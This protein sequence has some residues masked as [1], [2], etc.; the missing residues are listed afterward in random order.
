MA[1]LVLST[2]GNAL[3]G[4]IGGAIGALVG[5]SIDQQLLGP[6]RR[7]P[8]LGDLTVQTS[9]YGTQ[10]P[11]IYGAMRVAGTVIW[12]TDLVES[13]QTTGAKGQPDATYS[14]S[15]SIA[16]ALSSRPVASI[17]RIWADGKLLRGENGDFKVSTTFRFYNGSEDQQIDPLIGSIEEIAN[18]PAYRG[19]AV[20]VFENL[21]LADYGN[22]IPFLTFEIAADDETPSIGAILK[23]ASNGLV[24]SDAGQDILGYAAYGQSIRSAIEPLIDNYAIELFDDG[25]QLRTPSRSAQSVSEDDWGNSA[26]NNQ[27]ARIQREQIPARTLPGSLRLSFYDPARDYQTG[28]ARASA[29]EQQASEVKR[30]LPAATSASDAKSLVQRMLAIEWARRDRLTLRLPPR[31]LS[32]EPGDLLELQLNPGRWS[33]EKCTIDGFVVVTELLPAWSPSPVVLADAG[34]IITNQDVE[35]SPLSLALLDVGS[36]LPQ[37][38]TQPTLLLAASTA[39]ADWKRRSVQV[40]IPGLAFVTQTAGR[41]SVLGRALTILSLGEPYLID[42]I[43]S[44]DVELTDA[45]QWLTSCDDDALSAGTNL[46]AVG[47]ELIQ[48][49]EATPLA[50]GQFR[51]SRLLRGRGGTEWASSSHVVDD[52]FCVVELGTVQPLP[53]PSWSIGALVTAS[54]QD[55]P[56]AAAIV[57]ADPLRPPNPVNLTAAIQPTGDLVVNWTRRSRAGWAWFD[58]VDT[59]LA[60]RLEQYRITVTGQVGTME[61]WADQPS[62]SIPAGNLASLGPGVATLEVR[63]VGDFAASRP[64]Q[65]SITFP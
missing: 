58:E 59:P 19:S 37:T 2:V 51:L 49:G 11:R 23:D 6:A 64:A 30:E 48:F 35:A 41:K 21:E 56:D 33:V 32:L 40:T 42:T 14:Y 54:A 62:L 24:T 17:K 43:N 39:G 25:S 26:D 1:T 22:R 57:S 36:I 47:S 18:T 27:V 12:A 44:V 45:G 63:Q 60:E 50:Q 28:E 29:G 61:L 4:P 20:A 34:R 5:Q 38:S 3:G 65:I 16:V 31:Y 8:R 52:M 46:A 9:S 10:I 55:S 53:L 13:S 15:V 7:G